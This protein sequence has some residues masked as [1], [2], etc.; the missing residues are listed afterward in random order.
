MHKGVPGRQRL[1][2][3][4]A[5]SL[6]GHESDLNLAVWALCLAAVLAVGGGLR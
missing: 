6:A 3:A 5:S 2:R 4:L 1:L